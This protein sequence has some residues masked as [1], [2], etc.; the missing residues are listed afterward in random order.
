MWPNVEQLL[1]QAVFKQVVFEQQD[2]IQDSKIG[3][4][5][6]GEMTSK[7]ELSALGLLWCQGS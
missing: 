1:K 2:K 5:L 4:D 7:L 6:A 3:K